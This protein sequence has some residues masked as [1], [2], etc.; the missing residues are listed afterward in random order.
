MKEITKENVTWRELFGLA[1]VP[2]DD[3]DYTLFNSERSLDTPVGR[4]GRALLGDLKAAYDALEDG[5]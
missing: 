1:N 5:E 2:T 4:Y 3:P